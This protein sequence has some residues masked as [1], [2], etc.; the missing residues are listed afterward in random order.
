MCVWQLTHMPVVSEGLQEPMNDRR[1]ARKS[2][3]LQIQTQRLIY[4]QS[5][6]SEC[7][8]KKE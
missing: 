5:L 3:S 7:S 1:F 8:G 6:E 4:A 2:E